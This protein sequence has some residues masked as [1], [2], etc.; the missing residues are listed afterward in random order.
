MSKPQRSLWSSR[1]A[2]IITTSGSAVGLGNIW[3]FPYIARRPKRWW[4]FC[5]IL[6]FMHTRDRDPDYDR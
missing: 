4:S 3:K 1:L 5:L 6:P 2:F